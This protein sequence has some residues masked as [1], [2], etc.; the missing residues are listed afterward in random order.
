MDSFLGGW[1]AKVKSRRCHCV[2]SQGAL[3]TIVGPSWQ[4][5]VPAGG[6]MV[7]ESPCRDRPFLCVSM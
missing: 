4:R 6:F 7:P 1:V 3:S 2:N 5:G